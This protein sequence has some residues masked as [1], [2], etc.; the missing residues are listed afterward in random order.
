[1][2]MLLLKT[3]PLMIK[4]RVTSM[5]KNPLLLILAHLIKAPKIY[6]RNKKARKREIQ[7]TKV[8]TRKAQTSKG[9]RSKPLRRPAKVA[10]SRRKIL[11]RQSRR[12]Q[13]K[14]PNQ[15]QRR[16]LELTSTRTHSVST[17]CFREFYRA[18]FIALKTSLSRST[19]LIKTSTDSNPQMPL[20]R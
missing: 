13:K 6:Y 1:M 20:F 15:V 16:Q 8:Q 10:K 5:T 12:R 3:I 2:P 19:R 7:T 14:R 17:W 9:K 18:T 4:T 11:T